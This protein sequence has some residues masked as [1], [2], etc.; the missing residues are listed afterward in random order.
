MKY[1]YNRRISVLLLL[2][3]AAILCG[4]GGQKSGD[5]GGS[6]DKPAYEAGKTNV[7]VPESGNK[8][9]YEADPLTLDFSHTDQGYFIG[10]LSDADKTINIQVTGPDNVIYK[11]FLKTPD[12]DTVL[13]FTAGNGAYIVLAFESV[14]NDQYIP[15]LSQSVTV[16]LQ[17]TFL[18]FLYPNQYVS[19]TADSEAIKLAAELSANC[20]TDLDALQAIYEYIIKNITYDDD[21]AANVEAG[22]LPDIDETLRTKKGICFDYAALT[23]AM[24]RSLSIPA[25]LNIGYSG[26]IRHAWIDSYI[27]SIGWVENVIQFQGN[28]WEM[29]DPTFAAAL[30]SSELTKAYIG[31]G[32]NYT[33]QYVR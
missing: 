1:H 7:L 26:D 30:G 12:V 4:C 9:V 24:L 28:E 18:P 19:F 3:I 11:Y 23:V 33:L 13:P 29:I 22:Y 25:R 5:S 17:N 10:R 27:E 8:D 21:K 14:G 16:E 15:L 6:W 20:E 31:D 2:C 32:E